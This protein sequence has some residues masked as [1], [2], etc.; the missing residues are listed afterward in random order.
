MGEGS[1]CDTGCGGGGAVE[2]V[3][4]VAS[5]ELVEA[6]TDPE[7]GLASGLKAP[8]AWYDEAG[9]EIGDLCNGKTGRLK[10]KRASYLVQ[11]EWSNAARACVLAGKG[12]GQDEVIAEGD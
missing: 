1:G 2:R 12:K 9:G 6:V 10:S 8:L 3:T 11:K 7:V 4:S 5:H